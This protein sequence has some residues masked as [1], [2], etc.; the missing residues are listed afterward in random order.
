MQIC[1]SKKEITVCFVIQIARAASRIFL[2]PLV[3]SL[4]TGVF[5]DTCTC[6]HLFTLINLKIITV[7]VAMI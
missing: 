3:T 2:S 1:M 4:D 6:M 5:Y 7:T